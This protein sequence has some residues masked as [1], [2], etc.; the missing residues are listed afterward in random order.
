MTTRLRRRCGQLGISWATFGATR[1]HDSV[2]HRHEAEQG[3]GEQPPCSFSISALSPSNSGGASTLT[4]R[5]FQMK[6]NR[7][8]FKRLGALLFGI[9]TGS[10]ATYL[11]IQYTRPPVEPRHQVWFS[12]NPHYE[13]APE[14]LLYPEG[15]T[16][17]TLYP[18]KGF[19]AA[20]HSPDDISIHSTDLTNSDSSLKVGGYT[21]SAKASQ[22]NR[23]TAERLVHTLCSISSY[24]PPGKMCIFQPAVLL[25]LTK[26]GTTYDMLFC[27][28]CREIQSSHDGGADISAQGV[29][30]FLKCFCDTHRIS[31][32]S[33]SSDASKD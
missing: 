24:E 4:A 21:F 9:F 1:S 5:N 31:R 26:G 11:V 17:E 22:P 23:E 25:R 33:T 7:E 15:T 2:P 27:F 32:I 20:I 16:L 14:E 12:Q 6:R 3:V 30:S 29:E 10:F 19:L 28:T 13:E 18:D 8:V